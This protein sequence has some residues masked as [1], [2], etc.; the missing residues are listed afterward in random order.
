MSQ[1]WKWLG[2]SSKGIA[3]I[4]KPVFQRGLIILV[5]M[6]QA[7]KS[8]NDWMMKRLRVSSYSVLETGCLSSPLMQKT[9]KILESSWSSVHVGRSKKPG[10]DDN[11]CN[12]ASCPRFLWPYLLCHNRLYSP[13]VNWNI[14]FLPLVAFLGG[15]CWQQWEKLLNQSHNEQTHM[16][17]RRNGGKPCIKWMA[18]GITSLGDAQVSHPVEPFPILYPEKPQPKQNCGFPQLLEVPLIT[19]Q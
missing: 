2:A 3:P 12:V 11:I 9:R 17:E 18:A 4:S 13:S 7:A 16:W 8:G 1:D 5:Y 15:F 6:M 14:P 19:H 10:A